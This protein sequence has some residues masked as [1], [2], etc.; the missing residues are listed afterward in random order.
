M[1]LVERL[2]TGEP[3]KMDDVEKN[4]QYMVAAL[5]S[6]LSKAC[7]NCGEFGHKIWECSAKIIFKKPTVQCQICHDKS[8]PTSDCPM[9]R[10]GGKMYLI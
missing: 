10:F 8:H 5:D 4:N 2:L 9:K 1:D 6:V 7:E 3:E